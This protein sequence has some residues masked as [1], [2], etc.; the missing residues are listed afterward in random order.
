MERT[1]PDTLAPE[2][3]AVRERIEE[4]RRTRAKRT[5]MPEDLW[6]AA[7]ALAGDH[8]TWRISRALRV[9]YE[10]LKSRAMTP[11]PSPTPTSAP[12]FVDM[13]KVLVGVGAEGGSTTVDCRERMVRGCCC[14]CRAASSTC[15]RSSARSANRPDDPDHAANA[16][17]GCG[18]AH[19]F[20][21]RHRRTRQ[22]V[23]RAAAIGPF[24]RCR[25]RVLQPPTHVD[26]TSGLRGQGFGLAQKRLSAGRFRYWPKASEP[27]TPLQ[28]HE[29][30]VLL[31]GGDPSTTK[32]SPQWRPV[33]ARE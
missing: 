20:P 17:A 3:E 13:T 12:G 23:P 15:S 29:L 8:G 24:L 1:R 27:S 7:V 22:A 5:R 18:P 32:A 14:A 26:Q 31:R 2:I 11:A 30:H 25:V 4:W 28:A 10:G 19:R 9:R 6:Q 21:P 16:R 33:G